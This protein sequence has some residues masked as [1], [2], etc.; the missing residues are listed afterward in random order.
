MQHGP[1]QWI[2]W[3]KYSCRW[4]I[5]YLKCWFFNKNTHIRKDFPV[6][7]FGFQLYHLELYFLLLNLF[8]Y[9]NFLWQNLFTKLVRYN[10][11]FLPEQIFWEPQLF[12]FKISLFA[13]L[14]L[15]TNKKKCIVFLHYSAST[16]PNKITY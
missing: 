8:K 15:M 10:W 16:E 7:L 9:N 6:V 12:H 4:A 14:N 11:H 3:W 1:L 5:T 13:Y 2:K